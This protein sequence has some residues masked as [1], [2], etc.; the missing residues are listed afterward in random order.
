MSETMPTG[1]QPEQEDL[2]SITK[3]AEQVYP[4]NLPYAEKA[5]P[6]YI[7]D[8]MHQLGLS[9]E[10]LTEGEQEELASYVMHL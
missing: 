6:L 5:R 2:M 9:Q 3:L 4:S 1:G 8:R 7:K 10:A